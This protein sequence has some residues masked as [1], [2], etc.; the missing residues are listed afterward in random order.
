VTAEFVEAEVVDNGRA[1][2]ASTSGSGLGLLGVR[3]RIRMLGGS[4]EIGPRLTGGYRVRVRF[5]LALRAVAGVDDT[6][7]G[8]GLR[9]V[10]GGAA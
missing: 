6:D 3:E 2:G 4:T 5:P 7:T 1:R 8:G 9:P 10:A